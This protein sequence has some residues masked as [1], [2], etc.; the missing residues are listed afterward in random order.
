[1]E[2]PDESNPQEQTPTQPLTRLQA[3]TIINSLSGPRTFLD[4]RGLEIP[5]ATGSNI[6][7]N[8][9]PTNESISV[10]P[11]QSPDQAT[12]RPPRPNT[13]RATRTQS[14]AGTSHSDC[15][16]PQGDYIN[17]PIIN[18]TTPECKNQSGSE[19]SYTSSEDLNINRPLGLH[20]LNVDAIYELFHVCYNVESSIQ[21]IAVDFKL[22]QNLHTFR[23]WYRT[24]IIPEQE[25]VTF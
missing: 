8:F 9:Q 18:V 1:M 17:I 11:I 10:I 19:D 2:Y 4:Y 25:Q 24:P 5:I 12:S 20:I 3:N 15:D 23:I 21:H 13:T 7:N 6:G 22:D 14:I 16:T